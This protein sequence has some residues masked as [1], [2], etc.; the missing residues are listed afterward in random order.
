MPSHSATMLSSS[1]VPTRASTSPVKGQLLLVE[2][3]APSRNALK[4]LLTRAGW[5]VIPAVCVAD[6][7]AQLGRASPTAIVLDLM[8]PDGEGVEVLRAIRASGATPRV[9]IVTGPSD[10]N[11]LKD[12][13]AL[14]P[15]CI[16]QKPVDLT[17]LFQCLG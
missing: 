9:A 3:D 6:A 8:L 10:M 17:R 13:E 1:L 16:L 14:H 11:R 15:D 12:A 7:L 5:E 4:F 2:D